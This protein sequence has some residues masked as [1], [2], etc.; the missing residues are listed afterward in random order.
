MSQYNVR[1][2]SGTVPQLRRFQ[3]GYLQVRQLLPKRIRNRV[4]LWNQSCEP[5]LLFAIDAMVEQGDECIIVGGGYG[6]SSLFTAETASHVHTY[7]AG[8]E[9]ANR[10]TM[11]AMRHGYNNIDV[12]HAIV[13]QPHDIWG[14]PDGYL[15][16]AP[17]DLPDADCLILDCE[18]SEYGILQKR[19][20]DYD[21]LVVEHHPTKQPD[22]CDSRELLDGQFDSHQMGGETHPVYNY[23]RRAV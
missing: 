15:Q 2:N 6:L 19:R 13:G 9:N 21:K 17:S 16:V 8:R 4:D 22:G 7:E 10:I 11:N 5:E 1:E 18:G 12:Y 20:G 14:D 3:W 23:R